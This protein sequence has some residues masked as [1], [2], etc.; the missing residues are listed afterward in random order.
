MLPIVAGAAVGFW[1]GLKRIER[2]NAAKEAA[3]KTPATKLTVLSSHQFTQAKPAAVK[4]KRPSFNERLSQ[5]KG[6]R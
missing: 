4:H 6:R 2:E 5:P 3:A 1:R